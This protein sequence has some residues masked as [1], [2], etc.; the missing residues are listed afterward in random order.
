MTRGKLGE[1]GRKSRSE[2]RRVRQRWG[3]SRGARRGR[4]RDFHNKPPIGI[5][6]SQD[7]GSTHGSE[8]PT[9]TQPDKTQ[10]QCHV[11]HRYT[12]KSPMGC[13]SWVTHTIAVPGGQRHVLFNYIMPVGDRK[14]IET[15]NGKV[16]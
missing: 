15:V 2:I 12:L 7:A 1:H 14:Y 6:Y 4:E 11:T 9:H 13:G 3:V 10:T 16:K 8:G 5:M